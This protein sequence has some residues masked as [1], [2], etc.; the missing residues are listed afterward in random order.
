MALNSVKKAYNYLKKNGIEDTVYASAE[1]LLQHKSYVYTPISREE[2]DRQRQYEWRENILF[3]I[4]VPAYE[5]KV[6]FLRA[7][8]N[9]V[10]LQTYSNWELIIADAS[11]TERVKVCLWDYENEKRIKYVKLEENKGISSNTNAGIK[12]ATGAYIGLLDHDD[13]LASDALF[14]YAHMIEEGKRKGL[15]YAFIYSDEDKCDINGTKFY[16]PNIK[17]EFNL[18]LILTNNYICHFLMLKGSLM[19]K[20]LLRGAYDGAQD[21]DLV[22]RAY[23]ETFKRGM[24]GKEIAYGH[25]PKVLYHWRCHDDST[26]SNPESKLYAY[27]AGRRAVGDYFV[28]SGIKAKVNSSKHNG[29]FRIEYLDYL[30][31]PENSSHLARMQE[32]TESIR[33]KLAYTLFLN[34]YDVGAI[35]GPLIKKNKITGGILD[36][37]KTCPFDGM[38][39]HFSGYMHR[40]TLQQGAY[41]LDIRNIM[42]AESLGK[43]VLEVAENREHMHLFNRDLIEILKER[44][45][46]DDLNSPYIDVS[47]LLSKVSYE[48]F[49]Y[50]NASLELCKKISLE[51][52]G[53]YYDPAF[54]IEE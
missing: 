21:H 26:A 54:H 11:R 32:L 33:G 38:N 29:F 14:E 51:G 43:K 37:T 30:N 48:D 16:E 7:L 42:I 35:G 19:K 47:A 34:R 22:L 53:C 4:V 15:D 18:D 5:T 6:E 3:S 46:K 52:Y 28:K 10:L 39:I 41:A 31:Y 20:L 49:D 2:E 25:I 27:E 1:R 23:A 40:A 17:P 24:L 45:A 8:I 9:S 50:V 36:E 13:I 44:I 12:A